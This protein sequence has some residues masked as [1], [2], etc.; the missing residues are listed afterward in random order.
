MAGAEGRSPVM[1]RVPSLEGER[2]LKMRDGVYHLIVRHDMTLQQL[3]FFVVS[4]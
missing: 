3:L 2:E 1:E 4:Q